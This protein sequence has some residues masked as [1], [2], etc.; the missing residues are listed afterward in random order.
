M[1]RSPAA[2]HPP[3][4]LQ[5]TSTMSP[6]DLLASRIAVAR[7]GPDVQVS[8]MSQSAGPVYNLWLPGR[9]YILKLAKADTGR[10]LA[11]EARII[12]L[13]QQSAVPSPTVA[14]HGAD[15]HAGARYDHQERGC[16]HSVFA[17]RGP[18]RNAPMSAVSVDR[19]RMTSGRSLNQGGS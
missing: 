8:R 7:F 13:L 9:R 19:I 4:I 2:N 14:F 5:M 10:S 17:D 16:E 18:R 1:R 12:E 11:K 6:E 3:I 15:G